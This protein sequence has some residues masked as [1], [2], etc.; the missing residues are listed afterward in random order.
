VF[1][2]YPALAAVM[3]AGC[4]GLWLWRH[5]RASAI[6]ALAWLLYSIYESL[7]KA[8]VLCSGEC[9]IRV[10]LLV[11]YPLLIVLSAA[12]LITSVRALLAARGTDDP[13]A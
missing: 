3:A 8:R 10:D 2:Q 11:I 12:T 1:V 5:S 9:N 6:A 13:R 7:M 4:G